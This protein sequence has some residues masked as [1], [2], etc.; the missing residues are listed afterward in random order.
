MLKY[1]DLESYKFIRAI[2]KRNI[3]FISIKNRVRIA[4]KII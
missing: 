3:E 1:G 2:E 4:N